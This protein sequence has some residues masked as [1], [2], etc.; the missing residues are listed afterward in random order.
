[1]LEATLSRGDRRMGK[2]IYRAWE[3]GCRF[4][5]WSEQYNHDKWLQAFA[6]SGLDPA[7]YARR[8]RTLSELLPWGHIDIGV[9]RAFLERERQ[10]ALNQEDTPYC[11]TGRCNACGLQ[12]TS[13]CCKKEQGE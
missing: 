1:L 3:L 10:R 5:A 8:E 6:D 2:V 7:F 9:T 13:T 11:R 4:D 12:Y